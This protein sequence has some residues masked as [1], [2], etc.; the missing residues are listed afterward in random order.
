M[1]RTKQRFW[2]RVWSAILFGLI[3]LIMAIRVPA[4]QA[5]CDLSSD[6]D[7]QSVVA[8]WGE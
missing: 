2:M 5:G 8:R 7:R 3:F 6:V 4:E 1:K